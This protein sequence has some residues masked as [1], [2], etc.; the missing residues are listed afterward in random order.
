[1]DKTLHNHDES[2]K[3]LKLGSGLA[4]A[5]LQHLSFTDIRGE[6]EFENVYM[7]FSLNNG[8][9]GLTQF[10]EL[11]VM[12]DG[13]NRGELVLPTPSV[14]AYVKFGQQAWRPAEGRVICNWDRATLH[15]T[16][17]FELSDKSNSKLHILDGTFDVTVPENP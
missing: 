7:S 15:A 16:G 10:I 11:A 8:E 2:G 3:H 4:V 9:T 12:K 17:R 14:R 1:M 13:L 6:F 5:T